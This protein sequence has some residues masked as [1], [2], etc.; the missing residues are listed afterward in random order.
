MAQDGPQWQVL[1]VTAMTTLVLSQGL[2]LDCMHRLEG[3]E[4]LSVFYIVT[5]VSQ[6]A[7]AGQKA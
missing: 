5:F 6:S 1:L 4:I 7:K 2:Q 3:I